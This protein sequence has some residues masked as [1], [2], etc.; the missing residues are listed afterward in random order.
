VSTDSDL[1]GAIDGGFFGGPGNPREPSASLSLSSVPIGTDSPGTVPDPLHV[2]PIRGDPYPLELV[3]G[4]ALMGVPPPKPQQLVIASVLQAEQAPGVPVHEQV[5]VCSVRRTAKTTTVWGVL[6]GR[7]ARR[8]GYQVVTTAQTGIKARER[9]LSVARPMMRNNVGRYRVLRGTGAE[10]IEWTNGSRLWVVPPIG[11]A[12]LGDAADAILFD[13]AQVHRPDATA[14]LL[15]G[16]LALMDTR[17]GGQ[18]IVAGTAGLHRDGMLWD[19]LEAGRTGAGGI[20]EYAAPEHADPT[21]EAVWM[22][23]HPGISSGLTTIEKVRTRFRQLPLSR[24]Q[25]EYLGQWPYDVTSRAIDPDDWSAARLEAFPPRPARYALAYDIAPDQ[26]AG[27]LVAAWRDDAGDAWWEV[28]DH[29]P[30][31]AWLAPAV[32]AITREHRDVRTGFD[33]VHAANVAVAD[34]L[35]REARPRPRL[36]PLGTRE[37][38]A[39]AAQAA[40]QLRTR[41]VHFHADPALDA[42]AEA[43]TRR[44]IG[45][46]SWAWGR[47]RSNGDISPLVAATNALKVW[48]MDTRTPGGTVLVIGEG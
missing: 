3:D 10:A 21:D 47:R 23:A 24:F 27:A 45:D 29:R 42:A 26:S 34:R 35:H 8:P 19:Y 12:F 15:G 25:R 22:L 44:N 39:A 13:E 30:G 2:S 14:D 1:F 20:V 36:V 41:R 17:A 40:Q 31:D 4:L 11:D 46:A 37:I 18:V 33:N 16:A 9:F 48:D 5:A 28:V 38:T 32:H 7:C 6:L 43:A